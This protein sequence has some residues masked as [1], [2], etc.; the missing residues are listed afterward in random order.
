ME[1]LNDYHEANT[2]NTTR[3]NINKLRNLFQE[4]DLVKFAKSK[5]LATEIQEDRK[6]AE[7]VVHNLKPKPV[8]KD[9]ELE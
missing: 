1:T 9:E 5:P 2:I 7:E 6:D 3:E 4:A 8:S